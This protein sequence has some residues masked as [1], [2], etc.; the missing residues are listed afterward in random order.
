MTERGLRKV[1]IVDDDRDASAELGE[2]LECHECVVR[3]AASAAEAE[4]A[5]QEM[6]PD[7]ALLDIQLGG[8]SGIDLAARWT[9]APDAGPTV[10]LTSGRAPDAREIAHLKGKVT[11]FVLKPIDAYA[12]LALLDAL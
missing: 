5:M 9:A 7:V 10:I 11:S 8:E 1:L 6:R 2:L 12:L 4:A 3:T